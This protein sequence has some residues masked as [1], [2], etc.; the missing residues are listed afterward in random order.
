MDKVL[1][2]DS[3]R[4]KTNLAMGWID[5]KNAYDTVPHSWTIQSM[6]LHNIDHKIINLVQH[7]M[8]S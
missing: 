7:A 8:G 6:E 1:T 2:A 3:K 5:Y 4:R